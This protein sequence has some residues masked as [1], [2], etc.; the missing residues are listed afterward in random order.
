[1]RAYIDRYI[2]YIYVYSIHNQSLPLGGLDVLEIISLGEVHSKL[3]R[4]SA[5]SSLKIISSG[6]SPEKKT[7]KRVPWKLLWGNL[8]LF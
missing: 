4:K 7:Y 2:I 6:S 8:L 1:M 5:G 3:K